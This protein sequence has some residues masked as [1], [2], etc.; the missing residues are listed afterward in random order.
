VS[1]FKLIHFSDADGGLLLRDTVSGLECCIDSK[2]IGM[3]ASASASASIRDSRYAHLHD[4]IYHALDTVPNW[5]VYGHLS[6]ERHLQWSEKERLD[7]F[8]MLIRDVSKRFTGRRDLNSLGWFLREEGN[9]EHKRF[10]F[11][12]SITSDGFERTTPEVVCR[13]ISKQWTKIAKSTTKIKPWDESKGPLGRWYL[14]QIEQY[15][16][17]P[18]RLYHGDD[19]CRWKMSPSLF[20][21]I[22]Q[23]SIERPTQ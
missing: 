15:A 16:V 22:R 8:K 12:F 17:K 23:L 4:P 19:A 20:N 13:Y 5:F 3:D 6:L 2:G 9:G 21:K 10:H 7:K 1:S 11:H 18:S 14:T